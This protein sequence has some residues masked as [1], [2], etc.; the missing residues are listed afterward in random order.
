MS[1]LEIV[2]NFLLLLILAVRL[3]DVL[4]EPEDVKSYFIQ[5]LSLPEEG[6]NE[7]FNLSVDL[8]KVYKLIFSSD[9]GIDSNSTNEELNSRKNS[10]TDDGRYKRNIQAPVENYEIFMQDG[11]IS[12]RSRKHKNHNQRNYPVGGLVYK[13]INKSEDS[14]VIRL[15]NWGFGT[16]SNESKYMV[17][18]YDAV[19]IIEV[20]KVFFNISDMYFNIEYCGAICMCED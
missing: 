9:N 13:L 12:K 19:H 17:T 4:D 6:L 20:C 14:N 10:A 7:L 1:A 2:C 18:P 3:I 11:T 16:K 15:L 8:K 5:N